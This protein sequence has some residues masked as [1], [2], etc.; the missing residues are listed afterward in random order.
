MAH[1]RGRAVLGDGE[2]VTILPHP[3][4]VRPL[5]SLLLAGDDQVNLRTV[6]GALGALG[7]LGDE[8]ILN[9]LGSLDGA[10]LGRCAGVSRALR[11]FSRSDDLWKALVLQGVRGKLCYSGSWR[12][13]FLSSGLAGRVVGATEASIGAA[14][15]YSDALFAPWFC[16]TAALPSR[17]SAFENVTRV[18]GARLSVDEFE[19]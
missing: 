2:A 1:R 19:R 7:E 6:P 12:L 18:D 3:D 16:G 13:T 11:V 5:G 10:S 14:P 15:L 9:I 4:R 8:I 17:W